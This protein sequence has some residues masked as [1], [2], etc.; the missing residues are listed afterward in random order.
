MKPADH[1]AVV[2]A[3]FRKGL[4]RI[5]W[6]GLARAIVTHMLH[7]KRAGLRLLGVGAHVM[8]RCCL[9]WGGWVGGWMI[10]LLALAH[11]FDA[12]L[13]WVGWAGG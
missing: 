13:Y 10:T 9:G 11:A 3:R 7:D 4:L 2:R 8:P 5:A 12:L 1:P 6:N